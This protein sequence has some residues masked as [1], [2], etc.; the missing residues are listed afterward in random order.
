MSSNNLQLAKDFH[1]YIYHLQIFC[2]RPVYVRK[3]IFILSTVF[4]IFFSFGEKTLNE[5]R[6]AMGIKP[7]RK[8]RRWYWVLP[9]SNE[10]SDDE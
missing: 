3:L 10:G 7:Y 6:V 9:T 1:S 4:S 5:V 8:M 2:I